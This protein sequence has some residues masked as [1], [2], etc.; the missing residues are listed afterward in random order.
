MEQ[1]MDDD[2]LRQAFSFA[3]NPCRQASLSLSRQ[4]FVCPFNTYWLD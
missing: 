4:P 1:P 3:E 2:E